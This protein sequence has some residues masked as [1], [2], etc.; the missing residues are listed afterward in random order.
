MSWEM[1]EQERRLHG[2]VRIGRVVEVDASRARARV[3]LGGDAISDWLP[4]TSARSGAIS[5]WA[6]PAVDEQVVVVSPG[7]DSAQGVVVGSLYQ[8]AAPAP[9]SNGQMWGMKVGASFITMTDDGITLSSNGSTLELD[10][11]GIRLN[12]ARIDLN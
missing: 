11:S 10:A 4:W 8:D 2:V 7:G 1:G 6:P 3:S 5:E 12:G 9:A